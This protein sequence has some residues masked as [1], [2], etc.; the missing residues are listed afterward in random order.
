M[1]SRFYVRSVSLLLLL[2]H[3]PLLPAYAQGSADWQQRVKYEMDV[4]L[5]VD[6][7]RMEGRQ[8]ARYYNNSP[9]TL[10]RVFYHL[11]FNAF[12]PQSMMAERNRH[13]PDPDARIV[14]RIF[15]LGPDEIGYHR[16]ESLTQDGRPVEFYVTDTVME[17]ALAQP[18]PPGGS[19]D[20][21]MAF[22]SQVPLQTRRSGRDS[23]EGIDYSMTQ[24]YPKLAN[25]DERGWHADPY[26]GREFYAPFGTFDVRITLPS[27]YVIGA[28]GV[29][30][31]AEGIGHGYDTTATVPDTDS[32]TWHFH[33]E[34]VH[35]FAWAAD[36]DYVHDVITSGG[37]DHHL[38]YQPDVAEAW[39]G[40]RE[41]LPA[42]ME[43][44]S[45]NFGP[46]PYPQVT[47][48]QGADGGMEYPMITLIT[49]R[50][51][52]RSVLGVTAHEIAHMWYY[53]VLGSNEADYAWLDEGFTSYASTEVMAHLDG[54]PQASHVGAYYAVLSAH[55]YGFFEH[56]NTPSDW[57][58]TNAG[59]SAAAYAG[60]QMIVDMLGYVI[61]DSLRDR[62][63]LEY[64]D[65]LKFRHPNPYDVEKVAEDVSGLHLDWYFE[66]FTN[67]NR[68]VDYA[69]DDVRTRRADDQW[70][71][72]IVIE[73]E[74]DVVLPVDLRLTYDDGS[75]QWVNIPLGI[76]QGHKP[77]PDDW[78]VADPWM[79]T[80]PEYKLELKH[81][82]RLIRVQIDPTLHTPDVNRLNNSN[83]FPVNF[84]FLQAPPLSLSSYSVGWRPLLQY[85]HNFGMA[86]GLQ[87]RGTYLFDQFRTRAMLK[88]WPEVVFSGGEEPEVRRVREDDVSAFDGIDFELN[89]SDHLERIGPYGQVSFQSQK[90][91]G[92]LQNDL[93]FT[94]PLHRFDLLRASEHRVTVGLLHQLRTTDRSLA[95]AASF[96]FF[97][98][99][100]LSGHLT[101]TF[102]DARSRF[103]IGAEVG[104]TI[105][106]LL[107][108]ASANRV[109]V[110]AARAVPLGLLTAGARVRLGW[111]AGNLA[112]QKQFRLGAASFEDRWDNDAYRTVAA[113]FEDPL[114]DPHWIGFA[115]PGPVAYTRSTL[116][117][118][119]GDIL[120][121]AP[122]GNHTVAASAV[123]V[124]EPFTRNAWLRPLQ[125]ELFVGGGEVWNHPDFIEGFSLDR[126]L[127]DAGVGFRYDM[128]KLRALQ[129]WT[130]QSDV[131]SGMK[132]TA[133]F[134]LWASD[135]DRRGSTEAF[136][137]RWLIG[138]T[139]D[140]A[141]W[142]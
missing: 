77:V 78:I 98:D 31:N 16:V 140:D 5:L 48:I 75:Q 26:V 70:H 83:R 19:A 134:P 51:P 110:D 47:V 23:N 80:F 37:I 41:D 40:L 68:T 141:P 142:Y 106:D 82:Q 74:G 81:R 99:D 66:Q 59:Y 10:D 124:A 87:F 57:F 117:T 79:W 11:Y 14:P 33:A 35:D 22:H 4:S 139:V 126:L 6:R 61:S 71:T 91:L 115:G 88:V 111:G 15:H 56:F 73:R 114:D 132:L 76:M 108:S 112:L 89:F 64:F 21:E 2:S 102:T 67:S 8:V 95:T 131:L 18:I 36:P 72:E 1:Q 32:L 118:G 3:F 128:S 34:N 60:G 24:W 103:E 49:G 52:P 93:A 92:I 107:V 121:D 86:G 125:A 135:E 30:Q 7:H 84:T 85:A 9:D 96:G 120:F 43:F 62:F 63:L 17:V 100:M 50:R 105:D 109:Y 113:V 55:E 116:N 46:Y 90:H 13:L 54:I 20:F 42:M 104:G 25:Y 28:T 133:K 138:I 122:V 101:Y 94:T 39:A 38:L 44:Y 27:E 12:H 53:G 130:A 45:E 29:L 123:L 127:F 136:D 97:P 129:R 58:S 119:L 137:F 65:R 69:V